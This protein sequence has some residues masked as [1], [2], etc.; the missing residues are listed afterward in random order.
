MFTGH[1]DG[2]KDCKR[3]GG[4]VSARPA[5]KTPAPKAPE[6]SPAQ[7]F[8]SVSAS[9]ETSAVAPASP[10]SP[11]SLPAAPAESRTP[12]GQWEYR[13]TSGSA[14]PIPEVADGTTPVAKGSRVLR[15]AVYRVDRA[16]GGV[17]YTN[18][19]PGGSKGRA[20]TMLFSYIATCAACDLHSPINWNSVALNLTAYGDV[21]H[22]ASGEFGVDEALLRA[23][24]HAESAFNPRAMSVKGAQG[25]MQLIPS[26]A[27]DM[28]VLDA[29]D[30]NQ[31]IRGGAR[32]LAMLLKNFNGDERLAA[33][34]YNAGP[35]AVL[36]YNGVPPYDET[37]VYVERVGQLRKRYGDSI[38]AARPSGVGVPL[39][40]RSGGA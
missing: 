24:I 6:L 35:G 25:L 17:E 29:F 23:I 19:P 13:E 11:S 15:G 12:K 27:R 3:I 40:L 9:A 30:A 21:I 10:A 8:A 5:K 20:V 33:A 1:T 2:Y 22:S 31:N 38:K 16:D 39:A 36:K 26:T 7:V 18:V 37:R 34:A 14:A 28:G 4:T 32:Y